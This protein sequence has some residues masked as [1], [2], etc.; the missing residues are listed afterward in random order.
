MS[1][2]RM[3]TSFDGLV[4]LLA[5]SLYSE[6]DVFIRELIQ[7]AHDAIKLRRVQE[8]EV[9]GHIDVTIDL[10]HRTITFRDNGSGMGKQE[11]EDYLTTIGVSGTGTQTQALAQ[12]HISAETIGQ[13][14]VGLLSAFVVADAIQ[15]TTRKL[16]GPTWRWHS[17][18]GEEYDLV[19]ASDP[20][21]PAGTEVL[22]TVGKDHLIHIAEDAVKATIKRYAEFI[23]FRIFLNGTGPVNEVDAPWHRPRSAYAGERDYRKKL[24]EF[25]ARRYPDV[26]LHVIPIDF[27]N[28]KAVGALYISDR[29]IPD[30][31]TTG[32]I[33]IFQERMC[34]RLEDRELMPPWA[35]FVRGVIDSPDL[36][37]TAARDAIIKN[38]RYY[39][40]QSALGETI[41]KTLKD[42]SRDEPER[43]ARICRWHHFHLK[44]MAL[45]HDDFFRAVIDLLPFETN[46][47]EMNLPTFIKRQNIPEPG[48][49]V[50]I[51]F[52]SFGHDAN[53]FYDIA[54]ARK[55]LVINTGQRFDEEVVREYVARNSAALE[56]RQL[57]SLDDKTLYEELTDEER[58]PFLALEGAI[59][60]AMETVNVP[61][62]VRTRRIRP[63][64]LS[65]VIVQTEQL[66]SLQKL[67]GFMETAAVGDSAFDDLARQMEAELKRQ[68]LDY[69]VNAE[70][71]IIKRLINMSDITEPAR[72]DLLFSLYNAAVLNS[73][74]RLTHDN[75]KRF[76]RQIHHQI[77]E[78]LDLEAELEILRDERARLRDKIINHDTA[79]GESDAEA[80]DWV[81]IFVMMP[82]AAD[83]S[84]LET[85]LRNIFEAPP[86]WFDLQL[87]RD[88]VFKRGLVDNLR[89]HLLGSDAYIADATLLSANVMLEL[90]RIHL[91]EDLVDRPLFVLWCA[92]EAHSPKPPVDLGDILYV[93]RRELSFPA[94]IDSIRAEIKPYAGYL[95]R[96]KQT[97]PKRY[98]SQTVL[99]AANIGEIQS[100]LLRKRYKTVEEVEADE[101]KP[102]D[103]FE[104]KGA[105]YSALAGLKRLK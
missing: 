3:K 32:V 21:R 60:R 40:L 54:N 100:E 56:L 57:D 63:D 92:S 2:G 28:P 5:K 23:P 78:R 50:P 101:T 71:N 49:K 66:E 35:K 88:T 80:R 83:Y 76:Y 74:H 70:N 86:Y 31:N 45:R 96:L 62:R 94:L 42:L 4:K 104:L 52:F 1:K 24:S 17:T 93:N 77:T 103:D 8:P 72:R 39:A 37:P 41:I 46:Q 18:G 20:T 22:V 98:L 6:P 81:R 68:R 85:A 64:T 14:G 58:E 91:S 82:Y 51:Y 105:F 16:N 73:M 95:E 27:A 10:D 33:D 47:G 15:V 97:R 99:R 25:L 48:G 34:V 75:A 26:P 55:I 13:F 53:Q 61:V 90:G 89:V 9:E 44:G 87:A 43:F 29:H 69:Y 79:N 12:R 36:Q 102:P 7:N 11:I 19:E 38:N 65:G 84:A 30:I 67:R 59:E